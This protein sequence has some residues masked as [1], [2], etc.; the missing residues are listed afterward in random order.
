M[1]ILGVYIFL[2]FLAFLQNTF[3]GVF[4]IKC[5]YDCYL[6]D[7]IVDFGHKFSFGLEV[8]SKPELLIAIAKLIRNSDALLVCNGYKVCFFVCF[9]PLWEI[10]ILSFNIS[11]EK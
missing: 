7:N 4:P 8:G 2:N 1:L 3:Q 10:N 9:S 5:N 6:L 11:A